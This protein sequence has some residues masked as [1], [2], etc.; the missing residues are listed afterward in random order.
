MVLVFWWKWFSS[1]VQIVLQRSF[2]AATD[3]QPRKDFRHCS[4]AL[5]NHGLV[6]CDRVG[7]SDEETH[8]LTELF[9]IQGICTDT[10]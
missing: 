8:Y 1:L 2:A 5:P 10:G 4:L 9:H 6:S 3:P 7:S